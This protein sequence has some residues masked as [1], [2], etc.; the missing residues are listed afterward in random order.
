MK[1][2]KPNPLRGTNK[3]RLSYFGQY[4]LNSINHGKLGFE[5]ESTSLRRQAYT[6]IT[7]SSPSAS[8]ERLAMAGRRNPRK[9]PVDPV[10]PV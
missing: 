1:V 9:N 5:G 6:I 2:M 7:L 8:P 4:L 3:L 10:N